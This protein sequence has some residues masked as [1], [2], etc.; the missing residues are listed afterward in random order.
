MGQSGSCNFKVVVIGA[1]YPLHP[2]VFEEIAKIGNEALVNA[3]RHS[4]A[5][6]IETE[7]NF[8]PSE[9]RICIRDDGMGIEDDIL[10]RGYRYGHLGLPGMRERAQ[11]IGAHLDLCT[12]PG[13][14]TEIEL[15]ISAA[16]A[17]AS[18]SDRVISRLR[19]LRR[20]N[21]KEASSA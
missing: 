11:K 14:C 13:V 12:R 18:R 5:K 6:S 3:F 21:Q 2:V 1:V 16:L 7:L 4:G 17:Y 15:R 20:N 9:L 19:R 10:Q 8:E